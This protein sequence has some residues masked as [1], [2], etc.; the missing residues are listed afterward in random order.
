M[1][2]LL[3]ASE[4]TTWRRVGSASAAKTRA[5]PRARVRPGTARRAP[6]APPCAGRRPGAQAALGDDEAG[7]VGTGVE[8]PHDARGLPSPQRKHE[9]ALALDLL[10]DALALLAVVP[11][12]AHVAAL[13]GL[14]L[15][16]VG[17]PALELARGR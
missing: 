4:R 10:D 7:A 3:R 11:L 5:E 8:R 16:V 17:E 1:T 13:L 12:D 14:E 9:P 6:R 2:A 15:D